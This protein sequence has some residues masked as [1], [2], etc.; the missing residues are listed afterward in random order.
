MGVRI[1]SGGL[2]SHDYIAALA[3]PAARPSAS[4]IV[5]ASVRMT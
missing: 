4:N 2:E 5:T 3:A 1:P